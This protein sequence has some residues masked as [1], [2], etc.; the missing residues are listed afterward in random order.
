LLA[1]PEDTLPEI[2]RTLDQIDRHRQ[3]V[4]VEVQF[5]TVAAD[6][7]PA[8]LPAAGADLTAALDALKQKGAVAT[9]KSLRVTGLEHQKLHTMEGNHKPTVSGAS[10]N[11]RGFAQSSV[12]YQNV[13]TTVT[14][15]ARVTADR[16][17]GLD[18]DVQDAGLTTPADGVP[19]GNDAGGKPLTA[20][21]HGTLT[22]QTRLSLT[23]GQP[24]LVQDQRAAG[25]PQTLL[26][27]TARLAEEGKAK[28]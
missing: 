27:V 15:T 19:L 16:Q 18:L 25:K 4:T 7:G 3:L 14:A 22:V 13:G 8:E 28:K 11:A 5:L 26:V 21:E 9:Q 2:L 6:K 20:A 24:V 17:I 1:A 23:P 12:T 10:V